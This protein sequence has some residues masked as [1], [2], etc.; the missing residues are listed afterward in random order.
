MTRHKAP[1]AQTGDVLARFGRWTITCND[2]GY[3]VLVQYE[4]GK[5][6]YLT[7]D[8]ASQLANAILEALRNDPAR[9]YPSE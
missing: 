9:G 4:D 8:G 5:R 7:H 1:S 2:P 3:S 6:R